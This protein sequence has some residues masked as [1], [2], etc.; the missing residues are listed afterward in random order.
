MAVLIVADG[1]V[2][3]PPALEASG[4]VRVVP[5]DIWLDEEP[6]RADRNEF[7]RILRQGTF[8][9]TTPP[10]VSALT[11]AY[12]H[13]DLVL[14]LHV[15]AELS[16]TVT[17]AR[18]AA[19]RAGAGV[20][21]V[22]TRSFSVGAGLL[23][24]AVDRAALDPLRGE[25]IVDVATNLPDELHTFVVV[26]DAEALRRSGRAGLLPTDHLA[27]G[28]PLL[29]AVRGRAIVLDQPKD[30]ARALRQLVT[31][32][33]RSTD[34][35]VGNWALGHGDATDVDHVTDL[36]TKSFGHPPDFAVA[37]DPTVGAHVG[38]DALVV[39]VMPGRAER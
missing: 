36:L 33:R 32:A 1:A 24:A 27:R 30:R 39:G 10:T 35:R 11:E 13:G 6:F 8:P 4:R 18:E 25:S 22:D 17:R 28:R 20:V 29:L 15:S 21:I 34:A 12:R 23:A 7:W 2:D 19:Q 37:V 5:G 16:A 31:H 14:G 3:L 26:Q 9:S 38:V